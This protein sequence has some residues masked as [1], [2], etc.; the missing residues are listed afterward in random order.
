MV[1]CP[2][3][4]RREFLA[5]LSAAVGAA[6]LARVPGGPGLIAPAATP[7]YSTPTGTWKILSLTVERSAP[8][9]VTGFGQSG[10]RYLPGLFSWKGVA[11][12]TLAAPQFELGDRFPI[13]VGH[14]QTRFRGLAK[15]TGRETWADGRV[16]VDFWGDGSLVQVADG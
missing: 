9:D 5:G 12:A 3:I 7:G 2:V 11:E 1:G 6:L 15:V 13:D 4:D 16:R 8:L 10:V 14:K